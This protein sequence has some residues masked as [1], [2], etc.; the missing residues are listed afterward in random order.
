MVKIYLLTKFQNNLSSLKWVI[1]RGDKRLVIMI[2]L[3]SIFQIFADFLVC[4]IWKQLRMIFFDWT[5]FMIAV[6]LI[7]AYFHDCTS[8]IVEILFRKSGVFSGLYF[9]RAWPPFWQFWVWLPLLKQTLGPCLSVP[10]SFLLLS[11]SAQW[12]HDLPRLL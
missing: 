3:V 9:I 1:S 6:K 5:Y 7:L 11:K 12:V 8:F 4:K 2:I 10:S